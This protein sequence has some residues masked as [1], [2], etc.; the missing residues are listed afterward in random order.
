MVN[1]E[2][3]F[4]VEKECLKK[5]TADAHQRNLN[6]A[7]RI[8]HCSTFTVLYKSL[9]ICVYLTIPHYFINLL[10]NVYN[11]SKCQKS[12]FYVKVGNYLS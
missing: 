9:L 1:C 12:V 11:L 7:H 10:N 8:D 4:L 5:K 6:I 3:N 2:K